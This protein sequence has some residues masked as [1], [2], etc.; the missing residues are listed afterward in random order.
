MRVRHARDRRR[1]FARGD[2]AHRRQAGRPGREEV[3]ED[4][5][6][7][8]HAPDV[9]GRLGD[10]AEAALA[11][12]HHLAHARAG[13]GA[14]HGTH[15]QHAGGGHHPQPARELGDVAVAVGLHPGRARRDPAAERRVG[16]AVGE[17]PAGPALGVQL[18][19]EVGAEYAG[20]HA[21]ELRGRVDGEHAVHA[22]HV[23]RDDGPRLAGLRLEAARDARAAAE[24]NYDGVGGERR[25]HH[26]HDLVL[27]TRPHHDVGK[28]AEVTAALADE[29][30]QALAAPVHDAI[31]LVARDMAGADRLLEA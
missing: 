7:G 25:L 20:L 19:L 3:A 10:D 17:V 2:V 26:G 31:V 13:R 23:D 24:R 11:A 12:Q 28:P 1:G 6:L 9:D 14:R 29:V 22:G 27:G 8:R 4:L 30:G 21:R 16:E 5:P 15:D 18:A